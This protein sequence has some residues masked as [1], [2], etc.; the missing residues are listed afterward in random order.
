M[1]ANKYNNE[2]ITRMIKLR[3]NLWQKIHGIN[4]AICWFN[5]DETQQQVFYRLNSQDILLD[6]YLYYVNRYN[7]LIHDKIKEIVKN[8]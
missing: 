8:E 1:S 7:K 5:G 3:N 2:V 4:L 6:A